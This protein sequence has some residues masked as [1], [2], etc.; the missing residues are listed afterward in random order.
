[1]FKPNR[2]PGDYTI[3]HDGTS[4]S[5]VTYFSLCDR[6]KY[7]NEKACSFFQFGN[8]FEEVSSKLTKLHSDNGVSSDLYVEIDAPEL[9]TSRRKYVIYI[10]SAF[11]HYF[12]NTISRILHVLK[13]DPDA[14]FVVVPS[15]IDLTEVGSEQGG[16]EFKK[17]LDYLAR[18]F[19][20][21]KTDYCVVKT[22]YRVNSSFSFPFSDV[23]VRPQP[24]N[25]NNNNKFSIYP[26]Y[27]ITNC[28]EVRDYDG[29]LMPSLSELADYMD[30]YV[31]PSVFEPGILEGR[32]EPKCKI[33]VSRRSAEPKFTVSDPEYPGHKDDVRIYNESVLEE[34]LMSKGFEIVYPEDFDR[35][36]KQIEKLASCSVLISPTGSSLINALFMP[37][38]STVIELKIE[39]L[40]CDPD[41]KT[42][43]IQYLL[44]DYVNLSY[45]KNQ[46]HIS[47]PVHDKQAETAIAG[48]ENLF[49]KLDLDKF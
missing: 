8:S 10:R 4:F 19:K 20:H 46:Q 39:L 38:G 5:G 49:S 6:F 7:I 9:N 17:N 14:Y 21:L 24:R 1:M 44:N 18:L 28:V 48:L 43:A 15:N 40:V 27:K 33:Y 37:K 13:H 42:N 32:G 36:D 34:Y 30:N 16:V 3:G 11:Y 23:V 35:L 22:V 2:L 26:V 47:I 12:I 25:F 45:G 29:S 31:V 41:G